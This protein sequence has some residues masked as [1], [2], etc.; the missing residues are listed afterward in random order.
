MLTNILRRGWPACRYLIIRF[1]M[2]ISLLA[3]LPIIVLFGWASPNITATLVRLAHRAGPAMSSRC[4]GTRPSA[5]VCG[6]C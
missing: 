2:G 1:C 6:S 5:G 4:S 3:V